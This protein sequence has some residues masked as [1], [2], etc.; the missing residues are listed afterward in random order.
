MPM[1]TIHASTVSHAG[2][3]TLLLGPPGAGK[4]QL[5]LR[6]IAAGAWLIADDQTNLRVDGGDLR[7]SAPAA[8]AG[9][10][11]VRGVGIVPAQRQESAI[12][13]LV[14]DLD[15][16]ARPEAQDDRLPDF[17][18]WAGAH[19]WGERGNH[20]RPIPCVYFDPFRPDAVEAA[21]AALALAQK[22]EDSRGPK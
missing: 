15:P 13:A 4:S 18:P 1:Q 22:W 17:T 3:A 11:E 6:L 7:A 14:L 16:F 10:L 5:A 9:L 19:G 2:H 21:L 12:V 8:I 20:L